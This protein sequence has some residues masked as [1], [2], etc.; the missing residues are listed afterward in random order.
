M[1]RTLEIRWF[2]DDKTDVEALHD[3]FDTLGNASSKERDDVYVLTDSPACNVKWRSGK[4]QTKRR[5][6]TPTPTTTPSGHT[7]WEE[8][9]H[10]WSFGTDD[11]APTDS[12]LWIDVYKARQQ[13]TKSL[14]SGIEIKIELTQIKACGETAWSVCI[15]AETTDPAQPLADALGHAKYLWLTDLPDVAF[16]QETSMGYARWL[17]HVAGRPLP[18]LPNGENG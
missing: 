12:A 9:W 18:P 17:H 5:M 16:T 11:N 2:V 3:W 15:E 10:K 13:V 6:R 4:I 8:C 7:G 14:P 1:D